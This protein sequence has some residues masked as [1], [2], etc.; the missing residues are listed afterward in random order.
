MA[1]SDPVHCVRVADADEIELQERLRAYVRQDMSRRQAGVTEEAGLIGIAQGSLTR[2]L[3][4]TRGA[5]VGVFAK[6]RR[7]LKIDWIRLLE[8]SPPKRFYVQGSEEPERV[9]PS[10]ASPSA[11][12]GRHHAGGKS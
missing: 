2:I 10:H 8:D 3:N 7:L 11:Q 9:I 4:G 1:G 6:V 5:K 12:P